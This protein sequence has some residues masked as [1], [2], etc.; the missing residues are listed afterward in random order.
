NYTRLADSAVKIIYTQG[1]PMRPDD[2]VWVADAEGNALPQGQVGRLMYRGPYT[3]RGYYKI[4]Q[5]HPSGIDPNGL[6]WSGA[7]HSIDP[8]GYT[9]V[10][11]RENA[12]YNRGG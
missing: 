4:P 10:Q 7:L 11:G 8:E 12:Q 5:H 2:E 1:Y 3:F 9:T 6:Y